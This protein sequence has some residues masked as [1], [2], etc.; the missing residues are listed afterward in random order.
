MYMYIHIHVARERE[1][2]VAGD[3]SRFPLHARA[4]LPGN[5][6]LFG[7]SEKDLLVEIRIHT[8]PDTTLENGEISRCMCVCVYGRYTPSVAFM[9]SFFSRT[10]H[11]ELPRKI[12]ED[13]VIAS[14][15][16]AHAAG[17]YYYHRPYMYIYIYL[18]APQVFCLLI[19]GSRDIA[20]TVFG[21]K[22]V[23]RA[24]LR[25][26][27]I[28]RVYAQGGQVVSRKRFNYATACVAA[29]KYIL[30]IND[31]SVCAVI[32]CVRVFLRC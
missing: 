10:Q 4:V 25:D 14:L 6:L 24:L 11:A 22:V 15:A 5:D 16:D 9:G 31:A 30:R 12:N 2:K 3:Q 27:I 20:Y 1:I 8:P 21:N 7:E 18:Y 32:L 17:D 19:K 13:S 29:A 23:T 28:Y 26:F